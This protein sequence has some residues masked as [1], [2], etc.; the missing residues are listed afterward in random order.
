MP[1]KDG[2]L[3]FDA[4]HASMGALQGSAGQSPVLVVRI[5]EKR[6]ELENLKQLRDLSG[7]LAVQM[8]ALEDKLSTLAD[9]T[10]G[11]FCRFQ[12]S[13]ITS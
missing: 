10:E 13:K 8:Q 3:G 11:L 1:L 7:G 9:G 4:R 5:N 2:T 12:N 6:A